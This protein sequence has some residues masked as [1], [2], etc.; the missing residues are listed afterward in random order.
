MTPNPHPSSH[1]RVVTFMFMTIALWS[2]GPILV[3]GLTFYYDSWTQNA[4]RYSVAAIALFAV[5]FVTRRPIFVLPRRLWGVL[6]LVV[7][8]NIMTQTLFARMFY[9]IYPAVGTL[10]GQINVLF[11]VA[12]SFTFHRDER[13]IIRSPYFIAGFILGLVGVVMIIL[14]RNPE[15]MSRLNVSEGRFWIGI[16]IT[17]LWSLG[18]AFYVVTIKPLVRTVDPFVAFTHVAWLTSL[19]LL[20]L[21]FTFGRVSDLWK[22]PLA[23]LWLLIWSGLLCISVAHVIYYASIRSI[24]VVIVATL[25]Q[26]APVLTCFI[27]AFWYKD[28]LTFLQIMGGIATIAGARL[29]SIAQTRL[30]RNERELK[31]ILAGEQNPS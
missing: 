7:A 18:S 13:G 3:K 23:P 10:V 4:I 24:K 9:Y 27:S 30:S 14:A 19:G 5:A 16:L 21:M 31:K 8:A 2:I 17:V 1:V 20:V 15:T 29:A 28:H 25:M 26:L 22:P 12:L 6:L 11:V